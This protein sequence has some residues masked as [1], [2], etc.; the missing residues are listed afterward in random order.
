[1]IGLPL[2]RA[3]IL[4]DAPTLGRV[5]FYRLFS[6]LHFLQCAAVQFLTLRAQLLGPQ[7]S[8]HVPVGQKPLV[9][10]P[11]SAAWLTNGIKLDRASSPTA[12]AT[13]KA[14]AFINLPPN[15]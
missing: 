13:V 10:L 15:N 5:N 9:T 11:C 6:V 4:I 2:T 12:S 7:N 1:V 8:G 3:L 14:S